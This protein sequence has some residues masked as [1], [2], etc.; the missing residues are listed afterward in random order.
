[1][2]LRKKLEAQEFVVM[3]ELEPP[4]GTDVTDLVANAA[5]VKGRVDAFVISEMGN[6][7]MRLSALGGC[8]LLQNRGLETVMQV[9]AGTAT[10]WPCRGTSWPP[11]LWGWRTSWR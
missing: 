11:P 1:M 2:Q 7:V 10:A 5:K 8:L 9:A 6:A 3:A 4:K